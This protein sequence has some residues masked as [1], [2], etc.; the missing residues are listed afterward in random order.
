MSTAMSP[1]TPVTPSRQTANGA[2][3]AGLPKRQMPFPIAAYVEAHIEQGPILE[4][5]GA[6][7]GAVSGVQ[8]LR[9]FEAEVTGQAAHAGTTPRSARR[10]AFMATLDLIGALRSLAN[11]EGDGV[12]FT[13]RLAI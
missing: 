6:V 7:I 12:R 8:G 3:E 1:S 2:A 9:W 5:R 10:D 13:A 11:D 4:R